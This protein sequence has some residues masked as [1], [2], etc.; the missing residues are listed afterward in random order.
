LKVIAYIRLVAAVPVFEVPSGVTKADLY[1]Y[2][3]TGYTGND[4]EAGKTRL[5]NHRDKEDGTWKAWL[6]V[7]SRT[8][9]MTGGY[10]SLQ[11]RP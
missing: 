8:D 6:M 1:D 4:L 5:A 11:T 3:L 9:L 10:K 2:L 7:S